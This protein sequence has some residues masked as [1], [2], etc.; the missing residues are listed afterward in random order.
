[1]AQGDEPRWSDRKQHSLSP[2]GRTLNRKLLL[3]I[4]KKLSSRQGYHLDLEGFA[5]SNKMIDVLSASNLN[6]M[7]ITWGGRECHSDAR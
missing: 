5:I 6:N 2:S 7:E 3:P 4:S 1:M